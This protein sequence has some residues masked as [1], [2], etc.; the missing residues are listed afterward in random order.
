M[1]KYY[2]MLNA[3]KFAVFA[4]CVHTLFPVMTS[5]VEC[6]VSS[7]WRLLVPLALRLQEDSEVQNVQWYKVL[8]QRPLA[9]QLPPPGVPS[10]PTSLSIY[11]PS[12]SLELSSSTYIFWNAAPLSLPSLMPIPTPPAFTTFCSPNM[13]YML[14]RGL[15]V[16]FSV[17]LTNHSMRKQVL[18]ISMPS[19][20][21]NSRVKVLSE[22]VLDRKA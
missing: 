15:S 12:Y 14:C 5:T 7:W 22:I 19:P 13:L 2:L 6:A 4:W 8:E 17:F 18:L 11:Y 21:Q 9:Y 10:P 20:Q 16:I 3:L 1:S